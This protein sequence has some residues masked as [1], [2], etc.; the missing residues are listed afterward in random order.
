M[1]IVAVLLTIA[2]TACSSDTT[3]PDTSGPAACSAAGGRCLIGSSVCPNRGAQ[4][5]NPYRNPGGAFCCLPCP[6]GKKENDAGTA[7]N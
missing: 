2:V 3:G 7:C 5:C 4:D 6:I 1:K